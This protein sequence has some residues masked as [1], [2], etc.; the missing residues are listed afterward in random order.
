MPHPPAQHRDHRKFR[1]KLLSSAS[2]RL[3]SDSDS[4]GLLAVPYG[5][6][7]AF[8]AIALLWWADSRSTITYSMDGPMTTITLG[9]S[10]LSTEEQE[11][12]TARELR[13]FLA[14]KDVLSRSPRQDHRELYDRVVAGV[15]LGNTDDHLRNHGFLA[16][17]GA[18][19]LSPA[20]EIGRAHV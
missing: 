4:G 15:A 20:F 1:P 3:A 17:R 16:D 2:G 8:L 12:E 18:W 13:A 10:N 7:I 14:E 5:V 19:R 9:G 11:I 6:L